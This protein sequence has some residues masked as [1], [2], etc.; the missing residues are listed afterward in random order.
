ME[1]RVRI[2]A[3]QIADLV[4]RKSAERVI[5][6]TPAQRE[7][8]RMRVRRHTDLAIARSLGVEVE[9]VQKWWRL[10]GVKGLLRLLEGIREQ[11]MKEPQTRG[12]Q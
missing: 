11:T 12:L 10:E 2:H 4:A 9:T 7:A 3:P 5:R 8:C 1:A 6:L